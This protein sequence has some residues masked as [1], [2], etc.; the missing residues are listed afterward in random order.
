VKKAVKLDV[1]VMVRPRGGDFCYTDAELDVMK[2]DIDVRISRLDP[3][4]PWAKRSLTRRAHEQ[5]FKAE[6]VAGVVFGILKPD[7]SVDVER[8]GELVR[9][10]RPLQVPCACHQSR[11]CHTRP[12]DQPVV[13]GVVCVLSRAGHVPPGVRHGEGPYASH[14]GHHLFGY[15]SFTPR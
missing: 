11:A 13:C 12:N 3:P 14:G 8:T 5:I 9:L 15:Y 10:A 7:G 6:G 1:F 2:D 4:L